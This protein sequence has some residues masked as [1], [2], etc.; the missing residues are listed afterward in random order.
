MRLALLGT[1]DQTIA[2]TK[3]AAV[4]G[5]YSIVLAAELG[6]R[7][8]EVNAIAPDALLSHDWGELVD[9]DSIDAVLVAADNAAARAEQLRLLIQIEMPVLVSHPISLSMLEYYELDMIRRETHSTVLPYLPARWHPAIE[10]YRDMLAGSH[11][12]LGAVEQVVFERF[13]DD[14][15]RGAVLRQ[16]ARDA[17]LLQSVVGQAT[18]LHAL[19]SAAGSTG[20]GPYGNL[21]VQMTCEH[22][23]VARW[24]VAPVEGQPG[25]RFSLI[26]TTGKAALWMPEDDHPWRLEIRRGGSAPGTQEFHGWDPPATAL[27]R[28]AAAIGGEQVEPNWTEAARTVELAE[29]IDVSLRRGRTIDLHRE[30][31]T[32]IGTFKGTMASVGCGLLMGGLGLVVLAAIAESIAVNAG[33]QDLAAIFGKW[34]DLMLIVLTVFLLTQL[35]LQVDCRHHRQRPGRHRRQIAEINRQRFVPDPSR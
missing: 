25:A 31:F 23:T 11:P 26:G 24:N 7:E 14:R 29:T 9:L 19:G 12:E 21:A 2:L 20:S 22:G 10:V 17:D 30:D 1:D 8:A 13:V 33:W 16:F 32:D 3:A 15:T 35:L 18:K 4:G 5:A 34:P 6:A 27:A 28:L